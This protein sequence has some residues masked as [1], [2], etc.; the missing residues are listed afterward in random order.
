MVI[1]DIEIYKMDT[2]AIEKATVS[3]NDKTIKVFFAVSSQYYDAFCTG[4]A[5]A[6]VIGLLPIAVKYNEDISIVGNKLSYELVKNLETILIPSLIEMGVGKKRIHFIA[7]TVD[8]QLNE[9]RNGATGISL[10]VDSFYTILTTKSNEIDDLITTIDCESESCL[11]K[12]NYYD[13]DEDYIVKQRVARELGL[14]II[15]IVTNL[16]EL[17]CS[18]FAYEQ[19]HTYHHLAAAMILA[20]RISNYYYAT[21][22]SNNDFRLS[23]KD[24]S[25]YD[26]LIQKSINY[27]LFRMHL[28]GGEISRVEKTRAI[29]NNCTVQKYL[30]VCFNT[31]TTRNRPNCS[32]CFKCIRTMVTLDLL[33]V[34]DE[35]D[36]VFDISMYSENKAMYWGDTIY[37]CF[38]MKDLLAKEILVEQRKINYKLPKG[39]IFAALMKG[40]SNQVKRMRDE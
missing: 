27:K 17:L 7:D 15:G 1:S 35:F 22:Y 5:D 32:C 40:I 4:I 18:E 10:G 31:H 25:H 8:N 20:K 28:S 24:S 21:G 37:R 39:T 11:Y 38:V 6:F 3:Y 34:I 14:S 13:L 19:I 16:A 2:W 30:K 36:R 26:V 29:A 33:G 12:K 23:F 9:K